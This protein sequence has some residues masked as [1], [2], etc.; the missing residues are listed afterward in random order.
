MRKS[1]GTR[2]ELQIVVRPFKIIPRVGGQR[3]SLAVCSCCAEGPDILVLALQQVT[4]SRA[5]C[6]AHGHFRKSPAPMNINW[7]SPLRY[8]YLPICNYFE[9]VFAEI[10]RYRYRSVII[11]NYF[12]LPI[13][14]PIPLRRSVPKYLPICLHPPQILADTD[15]D[16]QLLG[17][18]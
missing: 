2:R 1:A 4:T 11:S 12:L 16:L 18:N 15:T 3:S 9:L 13:P 8:F 17:I 10:F 5:H 6:W 14:V 7:H